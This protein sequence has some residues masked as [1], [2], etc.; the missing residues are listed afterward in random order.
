MVAH[1]PRSQPADA[2]MRAHDDL[3]VVRA[4]PEAAASDHRSEGPP[5]RPRHHGRRRGGGRPRP[6]PAG[7]RARSTAGRHPPLSGMFPRSR[8]PSHGMT[9]E[10]MRSDGQAQ[11]GACRPSRS[12]PSQPPAVARPAGTA[13]LAR[14]R[15]EC[16]RGHR[17]RAVSGHSRSSGRR[18]ASEATCVSAAREFRARRSRRGL[19]G[20]PERR[21]FRKRRRRRRRCR[22]G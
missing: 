6:R 14:R 17:E 21:G 19:A 5:G 15:F 4:G 2:A 8:P 16:C 13:D 3:I 1:R 18:Q 22:T 11:Q 7:R 12:P 10:G 20:L 9:A